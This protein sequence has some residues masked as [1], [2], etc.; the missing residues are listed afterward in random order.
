MLE[1]WLDYHRATVHFKC[2]GLSEDN[3]WQAP[4]P[5]APL[6]SAGGVVSHLV[7]VE[8]F[9][10]EYVVSGCEAEWPWPDDDPDIDFRRKD[11]ESL[12]SVL[13]RY[14]AQCA[15]SRELM[16]GLSMDSLTA[17]QRQHSDVSL[18]HV[19]LQ[20]IQETARHNGHLDAIRELIDGVV[21]E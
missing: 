5:E 2:A 16:R 14:A 10:A 1:A 7:M 4:L 21:G 8:R 18:R 15:T 3:A 11:G 17:R 12:A 13:T 6:M 9:W 19:Y 20:L